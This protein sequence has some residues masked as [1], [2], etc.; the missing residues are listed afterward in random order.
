MN[1]LKSMDIYTFYSDFSALPRL[2]L[3]ILCYVKTVCCAFC[4]V[5]YENTI[6]MRTVR[7]IKITA[8]DGKVVWAF[9]RHQ[10]QHSYLTPII[11]GSK[12]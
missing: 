8:M 5:Q 6:C 9:Q 10:N 3:F 1:V 11:W 7:D 4:F 12:T 2:T